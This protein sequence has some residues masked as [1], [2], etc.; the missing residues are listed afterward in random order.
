MKSRKPLYIEIRDWDQ[1]FISELTET[2]RDELDMIKEGDYCSVFE[3]VQV[4]A[5][6]EYLRNYSYLKF[7]FLNCILRQSVATWRYEWP[8]VNRPLCVRS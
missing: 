6:F 7:R 5:L 8:E 3:E 1:N 2:I 4:D